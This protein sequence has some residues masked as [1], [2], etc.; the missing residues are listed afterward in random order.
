MA[1]GWVDKGWE[2]S[3]NDL[4]L[5]HATIKCEL[6]LLLFYL[7]LYLFKQKLNIFYVGEGKIRFYDVFSTIFSYNLVLMLHLPC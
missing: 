7:I 1:Y 4:G 6:L 2:T 3:V 5:K